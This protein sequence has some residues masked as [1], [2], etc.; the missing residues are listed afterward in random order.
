ME[1]GLPASLCFTEDDSCAYRI[2]TGPRQP[3]GEERVERAGRLDLILRHDTALATGEADL[4]S[5]WWAL[6][7]TIGDTAASTHGA[8]GRACFWP[9]FVAARAE[10]FKH[11]H[12]RTPGTS[13]SLAAA[14]R[15]ADDQPPTAADRAA[16]PWQPG[17]SIYDSRTHVLVPFA[18]ETH[19][20]LGSLLSGSSTLWLA[21]PLA[22]PRA[23]RRGVAA[24]CSAG[25]FCSRSR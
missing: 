24:C 22:A 12:Y 9:G 16:P 8:R 11:H 13:T 17:E 14:F 23:T 15:K 25:G 21:T 6:D 5:R 2:V 20:R 1:A 18:M 7:I 3:G 19:G 4:N 10:C